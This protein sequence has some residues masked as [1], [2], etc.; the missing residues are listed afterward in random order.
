VKAKMINALNVFH[1]G[2]RRL[3]LGLM[4]VGNW[5]RKKDEI[6]KINLIKFCALPQHLENIN[7]VENFFN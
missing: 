5:P 1:G 2:V 7:L 6:I 3:E 4:V